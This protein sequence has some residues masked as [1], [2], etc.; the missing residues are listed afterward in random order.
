MT[1]GQGIGDEDAAVRAQAVVVE[2]EVLERDV[3][4]EEGDEGCLRED[5]ASGISLR[6][7]PVN[8]SDRSADWK[9]P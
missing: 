8:M 4:R 5:R 7:R 9:K 3:G 6:R 1:L 2:V